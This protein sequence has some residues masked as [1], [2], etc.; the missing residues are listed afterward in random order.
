MTFLVADAEGSITESDRAPR[1]GRAPVE[2]HAVV[3]QAVTDHSGTLLM[4]SG[5]TLVAAFTDP[6][7]ALMAAWEAQ[8]YL[9][10]ALVGA[11]PGGAV[12]MAVHTGPVVLRGEGDYAGHTL[13]HARRLQAIGHAGQVLMSAATVDGIT[14]R[15]PAGASLMDLGSRL[16]SG[17][18]RSE[19]VWQLAHPDLPAEFAPLRSLDTFRHNLP[20]QPTPL[21]GRVE[22]LADI[23]RA[24]DADRLV[25]LTGT[26]GVGKTRLAV[27]AAAER[28]ARHPDGVWL[29]ELATLTDPSGVASKVAGVLQV[30]ETTDSPTVEAIIR[31]VGD[32]RAL[33]VL[34]NCEHVVEACAELAEGLVTGCPQ[35]TVLATSREPLAVP[36]EVTWPVPPLPAP[37]FGWREDLVTLSRFDAVR[38][39]ADRARR[40]RPDFAIT[41][42]N[43]GAVADLCAR[44]DGVPLALELAAARCR[45]LTP[46]QI[47]R[48]LDQRFR[49]LTGGARTRLARQ[50]TLQASVSWSHDL[51]SSDE[52]AAFRRLGVFAGPFPLD[53]AEAICS[54][55]DLAP[56]AV[57]D[58]LS[59]LVDKSLLVH[60]PD[61]GWYRQLETMRVYALERCDDA[62]ELHHQR[63]VHARWWT[64]WLAA[65]GPDAPSDADVDVIDA[66]Y[67]NLRVALEWAA[68]TEPA[69]ALELA[70][71]LGVYWQLRGRLG[72]AITLGDLA[73][74]AGRDSHPQAWA[75]TVGLIA[76][77]RRYAGDSTFFTDIVPDACRI[78]E[79]A[80][81]QLTPL[82]C[83]A[84]PVL[85]IGTLGE[86]E[87]L[88]A[89]AQ[90]LGERWV[91]ARMRYCLTIYAPALVLPDEETGRRAR[92]L[93]RGLAESLDASTFRVGYHDSAA[94][95]IA[96]LDLAAA[97]QEAR[98]ALPLLDRATTS[99]A[100]RLLVDL[101]WLATLHG[102][103]ATA[104][105]L[106]RSASQ[107]PRDWGILAPLAAVLGQLPALLDGTTRWN[108]PLP[109]LP[110][111]EPG[112]T[113]LLSEI[114]AEH[115][116]HLQGLESGHTAGGGEVWNVGNLAHQ[117]RACFA[118]ARY[119]DAEPSIAQLVRRPYEDQHLWLLALAR[120]AASA[121]SLTEAARLLGA[122]ATHQARAAAPWLPRIL[123]TA[124]HETEDLARTALGDAAFEAAHAE[125]CALEL[126][127]A[128]TYAL[129]ARGER[130]RPASGWDSLTPTEM[131]VAEEV[132]A[133]R[134]NAEIATA[135][136]MGRTTVKTHLGHIFTKLGCAN[137]AELAAEATRRASTAPA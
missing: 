19:R 66:A 18:T 53:G 78:A 132:A 130:K 67:P 111:P 83:H 25:T 17:L 123:L 86:F 21:I 3:R 127:D 60:D 10:A 94:L 71:G 77:S 133:G 120:C 63:D 59:R 73:L 112:S 22:E 50:Q 113:W 82:R 91:E 100:L 34:D 16:L 57:F 119:R 115:L 51:L 75:H 81:D 29:V 40:A 37:P 31:F 45:S 72:D 114:A 126:H 84:A 128:V 2:R 24:L 76:N 11:S 1:D 88:A 68:A 134:T 118:A 92:E 48:Q 131:K 39:F 4:E 122:V 101:A 52:Q 41:D 26:A 46:E 80:G 12:R 110:L 15:L 69:L 7:D 109:S 14:G 47:D 54:G 55:A 116:I 27:H 106:A 49:L 137:R 33:L 28:V 30:W 58:A 42:A 102:D 38:L 79:T 136:L 107:S 32:R 36:G 124:R 13:D 70:G 103:R 64:A 65:L 44:L 135:L 85:S 90:R 99:T 121:G 74:D 87:A 129:R 43:A 96:P 62:G 35:L 9:H 97:V 95:S 5:A 20:S 89:A 125:G 108:E 56:W 105:L 8:R 117:T 104:D 23:G 61:T 6:A 98:A 93:L